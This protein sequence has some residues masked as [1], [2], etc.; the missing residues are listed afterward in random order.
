MTMR[1]ESLRDGRNTLVL[2]HGRDR[3]AAA[4]LVSRFKSLASGDV[5][6]VALH[7]IPGVSAIGGCQVLATNQPG[8][9]GIRRI[10]DPAS[11]RW[12]QDLEGWLQVAELAWPVTQSFESEGTHFQFLE[13]QGAEVILSTERSW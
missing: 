7:E 10:A 1:L 9:P 2:I 12:T 6:E 8:R 5:R 4:A 3:A 13:Q 11:Y